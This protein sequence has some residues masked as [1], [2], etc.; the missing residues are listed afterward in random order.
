MCHMLLSVMEEV[1]GVMSKVPD[2]GAD[3]N[4]TNCQI[5]RGVFGELL[6][7]FG[8]GANKP[9]SMLWQW[10]KPNSLLSEVTAMEQSF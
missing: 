8:S 7:V 4:N 3:F 5:V 10:F 9:L 2:P 1:K 6:C